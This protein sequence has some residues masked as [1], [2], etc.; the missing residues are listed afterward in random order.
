MSLLSV[1]HQ[2]AFLGDEFLIGLAL[3]Q[4]TSLHFVLLLLGPHAACPC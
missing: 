2:E 4:D 3:M 1:N